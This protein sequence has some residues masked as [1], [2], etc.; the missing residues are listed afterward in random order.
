MSLFNLIY[1]LSRKV[2]GGAFLL[3][4]LYSCDIPRKA[5]IGK[6]VVFGHRGLGVVINPKSVIEDGVTIQH[7]VTL[8][9]RTESGGAPIIHKNAHIGAYAMIL[10]DVEIGEN[11]VIG[12]GTLV[13][14]DVEANSTYVNKRTL[15]KLN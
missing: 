8:A 4:I 15:D 2:S 6:N 12:A 1:R 10:G 9:R 5:S 11:A 7:H 3:R 14:H 13:V